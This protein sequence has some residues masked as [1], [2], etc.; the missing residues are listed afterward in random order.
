VSTAAFARARASAYKIILTIIPMKN[1]N[2]YFEEDRL[3]GQL[4]EKK[5]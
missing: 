4:N 1:Q 3:R 5:F 2:F